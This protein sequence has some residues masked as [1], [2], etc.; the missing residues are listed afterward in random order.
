MSTKALLEFDSLTERE[1]EILHLIADGCSNH[2][3]AEQLV[4]SIATVKWYSS[5]MFSKLH[6]TSRTQAVARARELK[7][8][9]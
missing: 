7:L 3:I 2:E 8:L 9:A 4:L 6:V 1:L 5:E